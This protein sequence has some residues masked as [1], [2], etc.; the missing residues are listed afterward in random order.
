MGPSFDRIQFVPSLIGVPQTTHS[1][2]FNLSRVRSTRFSLLA[3]FSQER[4]DSRRDSRD[5][6]ACLE[7]LPAPH[8]KPITV[9]VGDKVPVED[10]VAAPCALR[11]GR[12]GT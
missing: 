10:L 8:V 7:N 11:C 1:S 4:A 3:S 9:S 6:L 5:M 12:H 2:R